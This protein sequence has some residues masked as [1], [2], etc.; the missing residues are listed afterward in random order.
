MKHLFLTLTAVVFAMQLIAQREILVSNMD[1]RIDINGD[2]IDV[3]DGRVIQ[4]GDRFYWYG[5]HYGSTTGF[6]RTNH[7]RSYSSPDLM[8]WT[9]E[10]PILDDQPSG[11]YY[12]PHVVY[13][14]ENKQYVLWYN[15]YPKLWE[16]RFGVATSDSPTGPFTIVN[17]NVQVA[18]SKLGVGDYSI[19]IDDDQTAYLSYN[20][21]N[22]H[23][24]SIERL[25]EN[26]LSSTLENGGFITNGCEAGAIFK[27]DQKYYL[28]TDYTCCFCTQGSGARVYISDTPLTGYKYQNNINRSQGTKAYDL[29]DWVKSPHEYRTLKRGKD[30]G[31]PPLEIDLDSSLPIDKIVVYQFTGNRKGMCGDTTARYTHDLIK[32]LD[33]KCKVNN[34][35]LLLDAK[36]VSLHRKATSIY[37]VDEIS[38]DGQ[39][40]VH[41]FTIEI[42]SSYI[43]DEVYLAEIE[44]YS[45]GKKIDLLR[46]GHS[47]MLRDFDPWHGRP[48]IPAQQTYLMELNT[49]EGRKFIWMGDLWG[50]ASDNVKGHDYQYWSP[51]LEFDQEG[52][53]KPMEWTNEWRVNLPPKN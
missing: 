38:L 49:T 18:H 31:F 35:D 8:T 28:L 6:V 41:Q 22:G 46:G 42:D 12:R 33:Y 9:P 36:G 45:K 10:G 40:E 51:P 30:G 27:K 13:H 26:Y 53:I 39:R 34:T 20:T 24:L 21:I 44:L 15:W 32:S 52:M 29:M 43:Y 5:T 23:Q 7:F 19:F 25:G 4:F 16:G 37:N 50:S 3:H 11:I 1:A 2:T 17:D 14:K 48:L 47:V